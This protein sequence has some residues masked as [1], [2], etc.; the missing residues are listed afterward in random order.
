MMNEPIFSIMTKNVITLAPSDSLGQARHLMLTHKIHH[1]PVVQ[2]G[3]KLVG[4]ISSWDLFKLGKSVEEIQ[5]ILVADAMTRNLA[6]MEA[7]QHIGAIA[8]VLLEQLFHAVPIVDEHGNLEGIV[9]TTDIIRYEYHKEY[10][11]NLDKFVQENM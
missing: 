3:R 6:T 8:E 9:T 4:M 7:D 10:P 11:E 2:D 1:L 5:H